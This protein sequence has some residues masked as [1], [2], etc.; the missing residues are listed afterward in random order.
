VCYRRAM[1]HT[2]ALAL[3][4]STTAAAEPDTL[5]GA[6]RVIDGDT[7]AIGDVVVRL[8]DVDAPEI[9]QTCEDG[10]AALRPCGAYVA[11]A[12]AQRIDGHKVRC[13][14]REL[15]QYDRRIATCEV[16]GEELSRWLVTNGLAMAFRQ[17]SERFVPDERAAREAR[18]GLWQADFQ[19]P[20][21]YRA[22]R[23]E[24]AAKEAPKGCPIKGNINRKG[25]RIYHT[26]W[27]SNWYGRTKIS[28]DQGERWFCSERQALTLAGV[29]SI[30]P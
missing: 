21:E 26:P 22:H 24:V 4:V 19:A 11:D 28:T 5:A 27:G 10:P 3:L 17:Y 2:L 14:V 16:V 6:A 20:W 12:L 25:E 15:D 1:R 7:F 8:A 23:W 29:A 13:T 9:A 18:A 30:A